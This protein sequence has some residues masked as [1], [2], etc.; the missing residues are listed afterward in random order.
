MGA[1]ISPCPSRAPTTAA[2]RLGLVDV[3]DVVGV[4]D[5]SW[6]GLGFD[7]TDVLDIYYDV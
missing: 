3:V 6:L 4:V 1:L 2:S 7:M 5:S